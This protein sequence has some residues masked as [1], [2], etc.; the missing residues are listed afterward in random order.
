MHGNVYGAG[1]PHSLSFSQGPD[2]ATI[3]HHAP[4][5]A[6]VVDSLQ[7]CNS[8]LHFVDGPLHRTM[9]DPDLL[10]F[11]AASP[12]RLHP[13]L[14]ELLAPVIVGCLLGILGYHYLVK[15]GAA[16]NRVNRSRQRS[17][18]TRQG[19][20]ACMDQYV[21]AL[22]D[23]AASNCLDQAM[24]AVY[25]PEE[26]G[27][28]LQQVLASLPDGCRKTLSFKRAGRT[29]MLQ[30]FS[31]QIDAASPKRSEPQQAR[32]RTAPLKPSTAEGSEATMPQRRS[33][34]GRRPSGQLPPVVSE[35]PEGSETS[36]EG[37]RELSHDSLPLPPL[38]EPEI[39]ARVP[40]TTRPL[41]RQSSSWI[42]Q[43][44]DS[45]SATSKTLDG[46][47]DRLSPQGSGTAGKR[48][49]K[50]ETG[51]EVVDQ[52]LS[53]FENQS[54]Q[55]PAEDL[56][57]CIRPDGSDWKLGTGSYGTVYRGLM[58][59]STP[60]AIKII[61]EQS[62]KEKLR[63]VQ[64]ISLLKNLR[65]TNIV[66]FIGALIDPEQI[67]LAAEFMPRGDL[68]HALRGDAQRLLSWSKRG[69]QVALDI[70]RGLVFMHSKTVVHLDI[71]SCN[72]L[73]SGSGAAKLGD[74]GLARVLSREGAQ[75]SVQGTFEW[76]A[77][78]VLM[79]QACTDKADIYSFGVVLWEIITGEEPHLRALRPIREDEAPSSIGRIVDSCRASDPSDRPSAVEVFELFTS[80]SSERPRPPSRALSARSKALPEDMQRPGGDPEQGV[81]HNPTGNAPRARRDS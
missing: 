62:Q 22:L 23:Y 28:A 19:S 44:F 65:H 36:E 1:Q 3:A 33:N 76:A 14:N 42:R 41:G 11:P 63:F 71:K 6:Q 78:E 32:A 4:Y 52:R 81:G 48:A 40:M 57:I 75:V 27:M 29:V 72:V 64:E 58:H 53:Q 12:D 5:T 37:S 46:P 50:S 56:A 18:K 10:D 26:V 31:G 35:I 59:Q 15:A 43:S 60:V 79:G 73:L 66:Q 68:W 74:V 70:I 34:L 25:S 2:Q 8:W 47:D 7:V 80:S 17:R 39:D 9:I 21:S 38:A 20:E 30:A 45:S 49:V 16:V 67:V 13:S 51:W 54:W 77:P 61:T 55:V 69:R 24:P